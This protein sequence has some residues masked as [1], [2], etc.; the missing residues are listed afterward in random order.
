MFSHC[1]KCHGVQDIC[2][3]DPG[4]SYAL[5]FC[6]WRNT[7]SHPR[8]HG[9]EVRVGSRVQSSVHCTHICFI[10]SPVFRSHIWTGCW[11]GGKRKGEREEDQVAT[12]LPW[13]LT[14]LLSVRRQQGGG[15]LH[16]L[17]QGFP[18]LTYFVD[19]T[20]KP[21]WGSKFCFR[22]NPSLAF[23]TILWWTL[24]VAKSG[25]TSLVAG[26]CPLDS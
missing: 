5:V 10:R 23:S 4:R 7:C 2:E 26:S 21:L 15:S 14:T 17:A 3:M 18:F 1:V 8:T 13:P 16:K 19:T 22:G 24:Q 9:W 25:K 20:A 11:P 6:R 12:M